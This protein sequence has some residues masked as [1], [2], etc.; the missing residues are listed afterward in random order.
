MC[1][2]FGSNWNLHT[3]FWTTLYAFTVLQYKVCCLMF[4]FGRYLHMLQHVYRSQNFTKPNQYVKCFHNPERALI[5]HNH[6]PLA[7]LGSGCTSYG[8]E[9]TDAQL[10]HYRADCVKTLKK[11]CTEYRQKSVLDTTIWKF[12]EKLILHTTVALKT[13][14]FL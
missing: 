8:I 14:G 13:L 9:T 3:Q 10:Q 4:I 7:C 11:S 2:T 1:H 5:L 6:F 12:K